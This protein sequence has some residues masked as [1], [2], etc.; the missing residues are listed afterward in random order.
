M[1]KSSRPGIRFD[2][3][4][5]AGMVAI[6]STLHPTSGF[7]PAEEWANA[8]THGIGMVLSIAGL[9]VAVVLASL[10]S[11]AYLITGTAIYGTSLLLL[12]L[13]SMMYHMARNLKWKRRFLAA[14][15]A[16][17]FLL[18]AGTY[19]PFCLGPMRGPAGWT[20]FGI[21]WGLAAAGILKEFFHPKRG[22]WLSTIIYLFMGWLVLAFLYPLATSVS[23]MVITMLVV[24]GVLY[25]LGVVFYK[26]RSLPYHHA[27]WHLFV[28]AGATSQYFAV[29]ALLS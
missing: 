19:P 7:S 24:G 23:T 21:I 15:H 14:D 1:Q 18:I 11:D 6:M 9:V 16:S 29:L 12:H 4:V 8:I 3:P 26:W 10:R 28:V 27:I 17:I 22:T 5:S 20:L 13:S 2:F 25:S